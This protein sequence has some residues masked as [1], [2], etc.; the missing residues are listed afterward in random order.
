MW[1]G[2]VQNKACSS[3]RCWCRT[4]SHWPTSHRSDGQTSSPPQPFYRPISL[5]FSEGKKPCSVLRCEVL[6]TVTWLMC[7]SWC[8]VCLPVQ[9]VDVFMEYN[10]IQQ[11]TSFLL[12]AL[13]NNRPAEGPLQ[14]RLLEM[15]LVHA[16]QV[17]MHITPTAI[18]CFLFHWL[19]DSILNEC[20]FFSHFRWLMPSWATRCSP[21]TTVPT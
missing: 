13:K 19:V 8:I 3:P 11:C 10:L 18:L 2:S 16:P 7:G 15:N 20:C 6:Y 12:D 5:T 17:H 21:T 9:I 1:W 4:R 14:T